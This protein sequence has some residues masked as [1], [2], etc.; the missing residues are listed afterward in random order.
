MLSLYQAPAGGLRRV[1]RAS[2]PDIFLFGIAVL[3]VNRAITAWF[4]RDLAILFAFRTGC[5]MHFPLSPDTVS[6]AGTASA[7]TLIE[8]HAVS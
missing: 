8:T 6:A 2:A 5:L 7:T 1:S 3:A 4:E